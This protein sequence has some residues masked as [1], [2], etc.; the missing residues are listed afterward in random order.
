MAGMEVPCGGLDRKD[1]DVLREKR[2]QRLGCAIWR[3]SALGF[4]ARYLT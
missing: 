2:V 1:R 4:D 3:G